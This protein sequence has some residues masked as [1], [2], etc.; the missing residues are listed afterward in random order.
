MLKLK[1]MNLR[2]RNNTPIVIED[3]ISEDIHAYAYFTHPQIEEIISMSHSPTWL[4]YLY[5]ITHT[6]LLESETPDYNIYLTLKKGLKLKYSR[7]IQT[8]FYFYFELQTECLNA[9]EGPSF[10]SLFLFSFSFF[11]WLLKSGRN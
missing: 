9:A 7:I 11:L 2:E 6:K 5:N 10:I 8:D 1:W 4:P 3:E